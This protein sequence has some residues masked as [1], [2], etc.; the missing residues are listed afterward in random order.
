MRHKRYK[1]DAERLAYWYFRLNGFLT[2]ENFIL[3]D[4]EGGPPRTEIDL[5]AL[6]LPY[7]R[8]ALRD[9]GGVVEFM[10]DAPQF[11]EK[12]I[13]IAAF[14]EVTTGQCK[15]NGPWTDKEKGNLPR[16]LRA[17]G[18]VPSDEVCDVAEHLYENGQ[19]QLPSIEIGLIAI[20][21]KKNPD[22]TE[23]MPS[24]P[25]L[26]WDDI[27]GFIFDR[28]AKYQKI[29][30]ERPQWDMDG[31]LLWKIFEENSPD[32]SAFASSLVLTTERPNLDEY[33]QSRIYKG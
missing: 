12:Q 29:K 27:K 17:L 2:I 16:A 4:E 19:Y 32:K 6:R 9:Y 15:L 31:H 10:E 13:P 18:V 26:F 11:S 28:F 5:I 30:R 22:L 20:G 8:E 1:F 24:V 23:R 33:Y 14:V 21:K 3:H 25:Q 7:R